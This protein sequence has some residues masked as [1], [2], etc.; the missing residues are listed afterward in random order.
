MS[1]GAITFDGKT[2]PVVRCTEGVESRRGASGASVIIAESAGRTVGIAVDGIQE[3]IPSPFGAGMGKMGERTQGAFAFV[4][5][6]GSRESEMFVVIDLERILAG[7][8]EEFSKL[9]ENAGMGGSLLR[10]SESM[11]GLDVG[12]RL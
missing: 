2:V 5:G 1:T 7:L 8:N 9:G 6:I 12:G 10:C 3:I 4:K 11:L